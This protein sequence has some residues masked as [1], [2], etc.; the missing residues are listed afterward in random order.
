MTKKCSNMYS[1]HRQ[2]GWKGL[3]DFS[4]TLR[5]LRFLTSP[6][7][8]SASLKL[9]HF[10]LLHAETSLAT[11]W[12]FYFPFSPQENKILFLSLGFPGYFFFVFTSKSLSTM[13]WKEKMPTH[14]TAVLR[15]KE[16]LLH[17]ICHTVF[18]LYGLCDF[19]FAMTDFEGTHLVYGLSQILSGGP[20][21]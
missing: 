4:L 18:S 15:G 6:V 14:A 16:M 2:Q 9:E 11:M 3:Y 5:I 12:V 8:G 20:E 17:H 10:P 19:C 21:V 13:L 7:H 1:L